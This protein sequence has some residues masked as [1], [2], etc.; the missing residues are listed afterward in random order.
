MVD[1][2][3][4]G[5]EIPAQLQIIGSDGATRWLAAS[6]TPVN[7]T[8][9]RPHLLILVVRDV[10]RA[11]EVERLKDDVVATV[12]HELRTPLTPIKGFAATLVESGD[13]L[14]AADRTTAARSILK[15]AEHLERLVVNLLDAAKLERGIDGEGHDAIIDVYSIAERIASE[16]R[17]AHHDRVIILD[18]QTNCR[19][20]GD[21]LFVGQIMSNLVSNAIKYAPADEPIEIRV[22]NGESGAEIAVTDR[23]PGIPQSEVERIFDRFHRLGNVLTRAAGGTGLGLYIAR[24]LAAAVGGTITVE[25]ALGEGSTFTLH[26]RHPA[27]LVAVS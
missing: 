3:A 12:S 17:S 19:A 21:E 26:L 25:S 14:S 5:V 8:D 9:S 2:W 18:G 4:S 27:R 6:S 1:R 20:R 11:H 7:D 10:T 23:G 15:Q 24:Q 22:T 16:F 13:S